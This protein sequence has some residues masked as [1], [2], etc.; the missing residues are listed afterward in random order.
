MKTPKKKHRIQSRSRFSL[1]AVLLAGA[2]IFP[3]V[4][5]AQAY[6]EP[7]GPPPDGVPTGGSTLEFLNG[8]TT[9]QTKAGSLILGERGG[10]L[11]HCTTSENGN[12]ARL[13]LNADANLWT[14][15][16]TNCISSW[17]DIASQASGNYLHLYNSSQQAGA[18]AD[19]GFITFQADGNSPKF[20]FISLLA[21]A[22]SIDNST[23]IQAASS[24]SSY[25]AG[26]LAGKTV[27][28]PE[29]GQTSICLNDD[30]K[31]S[32]AEVVGGVPNDVLELQSGQVYT[33]QDG[34]IGINGPIIVGS[35]VAGHP[36]AS[37]PASYT[38]GDGICSPENNE[39]T[40][41]PSDCSP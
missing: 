40:Q 8:S 1:A 6:V 32:W 39:Q 12:C 30:C 27:I 31:Q 9:A 14:T 22:N 3:L 20:Q 24:T 23:G 16:P 18:T 36:A 35:L 11:A 4:A 21:Q 15:D 29:S 13:C 38:C 33:P 28:L 26:Q 7:N 34:N 10:Q 19:S 41:C 5:G 25:Y 37:T 17:S 2:L